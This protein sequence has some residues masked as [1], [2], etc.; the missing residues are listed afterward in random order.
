M[1]AAGRVRS[2]VALIQQARGRRDS[3]QSRCQ[4]VLPKRTGISPLPLLIRFFQKKIDHLQGLTMRTGNL[5]EIVPKI[6]VI[7]SRRFSINGLHMA[8]VG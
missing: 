8:Y 6:G 4:A 3:A 7:R 2:P 5:K 1:V